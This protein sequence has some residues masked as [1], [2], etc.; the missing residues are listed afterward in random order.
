MILRLA[1]RS[2]LAHPVRSAVLAAGF[3]LGVAV[4]A[5]L[6]GVGEVILVQARSPS[7]RGGGDVLVAGAAGDIPLA[8]YL[9][10]NVLGRAPL[11]DRQRVASPSARTTLYLMRDGGRVVPVRAKGGIPSL[12]GALGDPETA[13]V[14]A[15][16][17]APRDSAWVTPDAGALLRTMDH[18][19]LVPDVPARAASWAEWLYFNG[20]AGDVRFYL[21]FMVGPK[22]PGGRRAGGV[23]L[24][25]EDHGR[26]TSYAHGAEVDE[27]ELM[28]AAPDL[29][30]GA[31]RVRLV[32]TRYEVALDLPS[33]EAGAPG[34]T[35]TFTLDAAAG[36]SM[37]PITI[38]GAGGWVSG[39]VVPVMSG[40][41]GGTLALGGRR[42]TL[43]GGTGY[44][45]H[46]WGFWEGVTWQWGQVQ[47]D[48]LSIVYGRVRPPAD[49]ADPARVPAFLAVLGPDGPLGYAS[50]VRIDE[51]DDPAAGRPTHIALVGRGPSL[52]L[53]LD[54][55]VDDA[56]VTPMT[57][58]AFGGG[59]D[60]LQ[61]HTRYRVSGHAG[62]RT[63][64]INAPGS[65]ET[66][67]GR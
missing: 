25:L 14:A 6:L 57:A 58:G 31:C 21:T 18:F 10:S 7:L 55:Q 56:V 33:K 38:R 4:M 9:L 29:T 3:G 36:R 8:R 43:D 32:G 41:L 53:A 59:M 64:D 50:D 30:I 52:E 54:L 19:H 26:R 40:T 65:S 51:T 61:M 16:T 28:A 66:F 39:Y 2:L 22:A 67:R 34:V 44:H 12:E 13:G 20:R 24:Q 5:T 27:A 35:G 17:D 63:I 1:L 49:A 60:F 42:I 15:W 45:D 23:R 48:D 46:N 37:P 11:V 47:Q 62:R